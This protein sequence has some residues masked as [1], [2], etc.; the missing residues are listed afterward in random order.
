MAEVISIGIAFLSFVVAIAAFYVAWQ[1][2]HR[3]MI[4]QRYSDLLSEYRTKE[5]G[6][7][8]FSIMDFYT[9]TCK[10]DKKSIIDGCNNFFKQNDDTAPKDAKPA[11]DKA[12]TLHFNRRLVDYFFWLLGD[13][14][15]NPHYPVRLPKSLVRQHFS[16]N[17]RYLLHILQHMNEAL[18]DEESAYHKM[19]W[20]DVKSID[21]CTCDFHT[22]KIQTSKERKSPMDEYRQKLYAESKNW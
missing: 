16:S 2:P 3:V 1:I 10:G 20:R 14:M 13:L 7:A 17:E 6:E 15:F 8:I 12:K 21:A 22:G 19:F 9:A 4:D 11:E 5:M 18:K